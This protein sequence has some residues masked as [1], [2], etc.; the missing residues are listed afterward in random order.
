MIAVTGQ[1]RVAQSSINCKA[2]TI[3]KILQ[4]ACSYWPY[5]NG[6]GING[7]EHTFFADRTLLRDASQARIP[8]HDA[9]FE[10]A[11]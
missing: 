3:S 9:L 5:R 1:T 10:T 4:S 11:R 8:N 2:Y 7:D 6:P